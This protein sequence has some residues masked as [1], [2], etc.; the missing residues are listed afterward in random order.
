MKKSYFIYLT[1]IQLC[2][3]G[4]NARVCFYGPASSQQGMLGTLVEIIACRL[5]GAKSLSKPICL[6]LLLMLILLIIVTADHE[7]C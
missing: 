5:V 6:F 4:I 1:Y 7:S 2:M 3:Y